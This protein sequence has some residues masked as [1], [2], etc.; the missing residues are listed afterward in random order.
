MP[1]ETKTYAIS[2]QRP[3]LPE[4]K[5]CKPNTLRMV[6]AFLRLLRFAKVSAS[7]PPPGFLDN[8]DDSSQIEGCFDG[9]TRRL[10]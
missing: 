8:K 10:K 6:V 1:I 3:L 2:S 5:E 4:P 9:S 7:P